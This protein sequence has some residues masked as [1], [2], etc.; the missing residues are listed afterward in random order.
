MLDTEDTKLL[1]AANAI[2]T[3][4]EEAER[5]GE[6]IA[7]ALHLRR[8]PEHRHRWQT[9]WGSKTSIGLAR[10]VIAQLATLAP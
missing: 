7:H 3:R 6:A 9:T 4:D 1:S 10:T 8:D 2:R 5:I